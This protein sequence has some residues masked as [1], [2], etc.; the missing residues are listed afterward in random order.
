MSLHPNRAMHGSVNSATQSADPVDVRNLGGNSDRCMDCAV[1]RHEK[2]KPVGLY[3][4]HGQG[5]N[6]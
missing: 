5:G 3:G 2:E 6:Q 1:G 4:C